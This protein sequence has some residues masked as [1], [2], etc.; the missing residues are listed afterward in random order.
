MLDTGYYITLHSTLQDVELSNTLHLRISGPLVLS[1]PSSVCSS[2]I[3]T[4]Y[5]TLHCLNTTY[6]HT[7]YD[8]C[9]L[10]CVLIVTS[11]W[12]HCLFTVS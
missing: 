7:H 11:L 5:R 3:S 1:T 6:G 4:K 12:C 8:V 10:P 2:W 9:T